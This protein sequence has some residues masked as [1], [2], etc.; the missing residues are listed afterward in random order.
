MDVRKKMLPIGIENFR[1]ICTEEY[2]YVDKTGL[3]RE[4]LENKGKVNL[5]TRP[6]RFGKTL[7]MSMLQY[8]FEYGSDGKVFEE[9]GIAQEKELCAKYMGKFPV[10]SVTL[11]GVSTLDFDSARAML[12]T[13][14]GNEAMRFQ[15]LSESEKLSETEK[16]SY[17]QLIRVDQTGTAKYVMPDDVLVDSLRTL[18]ELLCKHYGKQVI[19]LIDEYDVP[20]DTA[21]MYGYY[22]ELINLIRIFFDQSLK[23]N[24]SLAFAVLTGC[25]RIAKESIF[26]GLNNLKVFSVLDVCCGEY[27]GFSDQEV[28]KML[29]YYGFG[30]K[31]ESVKMWYGGYHF[32]N[33]DIYCPWD[34]INYVDLL[35]SGPDALPRA[36]WV[37]T[38]GNEIIRKFLQGA[39][40]GTKRELE[41][42]MEGKTVCKKINR[43]LMHRDLYQG[44]DYLWSVLFAT[45]YL[46]QRGNVDGDV[47]ALAIPNLGIRQIFA[48]QIMKWFQEESR[49]DTPRLAAFCEAFL[50]ADAKM[51]EE[52][53]NAYLLKTIGIRDTNVKK[54]KKENFYHRILLGLL[55]YRDDWWVYSNMEPGDGFCDIM[56]EHEG[57]EVG[58]IIEVKYPDGGNLEQ[59]CAEALEQIRRMGHESKLL[60]NEM[61]RILWYGIACNR[62]KCK[63]MFEVHDW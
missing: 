37:N 46:T 42:L 13:I 43:E 61:T 15:F 39:D 25:L 5:F 32:G 21:Q 38:G 63:V 59:G 28:R 53:F 27:F 24:N 35:C 44:M 2:Y 3:I 48:E 58:I 60:Q 11:K 57:Q 10:I 50:R 31:Y 33:K 4:L 8:F 18:S 40:A 7:N 22:D 29:E 51:V 62:K 54:A 23:T 16:E 12:R 47:L 30:E 14:V 52:Q 20:L 49:K 26:T 1:E 19:L 41:Q 45:G 34:V 56:V 17:R 9:L 36:F 55:S 6:G